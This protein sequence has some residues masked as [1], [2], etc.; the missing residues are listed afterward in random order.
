MQTLHSLQEL[1]PTPAIL[2]DSAG[3]RIMDGVVS[4]RIRSTKDLDAAVDTCGSGAHLVR[5]TRH[6]GVA[7]MLV[8]T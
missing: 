2:A 7:R 4:G 8:N 1:K 6:V 5:S 3:R